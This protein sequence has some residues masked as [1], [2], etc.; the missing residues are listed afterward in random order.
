MKRKRWKQVR[1]HRQPARFA[2][3]GKNP[4][5]KLGF[6]VWTTMASLGPWSYCSFL[7]LRKKAESCL[8]QYRSLLLVE[9]SMLSKFKV[10]LGCIPARGNCRKQ[11]ILEHNKVSHILQHREGKRSML[12]P[13]AG[14]CMA[15]SWQVKCQSHTARCQFSSLFCSPN[16]T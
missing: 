10:S 3:F 7:C 14:H 13:K 9:L 11:D 4:R 6:S 8:K 12:G 2:Q 15:L 16:Q 5:E 1:Q